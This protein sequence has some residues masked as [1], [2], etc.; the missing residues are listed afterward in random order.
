MAPLWH[1]FWAPAFDEGE[2]DFRAFDNGCADVLAFDLCG[3]NFPVG[4]EG[5]NGRGRQ[6]W[7]LYEQP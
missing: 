4:K 3:D 1:V 2:V 6:D 7:F 5:S